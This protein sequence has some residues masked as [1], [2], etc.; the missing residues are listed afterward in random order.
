MTDDDMDEASIRADQTRLIVEWLRSQMDD[1]RFADDWKRREGL[2]QT[3]ICVEAKFLSD[4]TA[5]A[6]QGLRDTADRMRDL[7]EGEER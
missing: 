2:W 1:Q 6:V 7:S 5:T 3:M 4:R